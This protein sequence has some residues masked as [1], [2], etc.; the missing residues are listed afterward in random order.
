MLI[1]GIVLDVW[2]W[3]DLVLIVDIVIILIELYICIVG[4]LLLNL[5]VIFK[6]VLE[7]YIKIWD[8]N[9]KLVGI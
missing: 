9:E 1:C 7:V 6:M 8:W 4:I 3:L 2:V 5:F